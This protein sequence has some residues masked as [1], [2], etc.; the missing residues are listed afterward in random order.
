M[1]ARAVAKLVGAKIGTLNAWIA[2]GYIRGLE[3]GISGK[4]RDIDASTALEIA[5]FAEMTRFGLSSDEAS[6]LVPRLHPL[7]PRDSHDRDLLPPDMPPPGGDWGDW[8]IVHRPGAQM[9]SG[10]RLQNAITVQAKSLAD[11]QKEFVEKIT[12]PAAALVI[13]IPALIARVLEAEREWQQHRGRKQP[14]G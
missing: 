14:D 1:N 2:R 3:V 8:L 5:I 11:Y 10:D 7:V 4:R 6:K 12:P 13:N 9:S